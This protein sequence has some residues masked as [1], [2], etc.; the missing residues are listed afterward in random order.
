[1][2]PA[3][4]N[5]T[6]PD[7]VCGN[8]ATAAGLSGTWRAVL[9]VS[10]VAANEIIVVSGAVQNTHG[11][12]LA[13]NATEFF[14]GTL[15]H[16]PNYD[17][18][19]A[20]VYDVNGGAGQSPYVWTGSTKVGYNYVPNCQSFGTTNASDAGYVGIVVQ[21]HYAAA[22]SWLYAGGSFAGGYSCGNQ[23]HVYC[24]DGQ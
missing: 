9:S 19:G 17:E 20:L 1:V 22:D 4:F 15:A 16:D 23:A 12:L 2:Y 10:T 24:I 13:N 11:E 3:N 18:T 8:A 14:I 7:Q 21:S 5:G 6:L